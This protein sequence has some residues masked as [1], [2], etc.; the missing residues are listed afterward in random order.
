MNDD[1]DT[2]EESENEANDHGDDRLK[3]ISNLDSVD[4]LDASNVEEADIEDEEVS[5]ASNLT[6]SPS[7][8]LVPASHTF[9][10]YI[11]Q[12][13]NAPILSA[14]QEWELA[15]KLREEN[16]L[17]A[18]QS[19]IFSN[20]RHVVSIARGYSGYGL[21]MPDLVQEG[22]VGLMKAV[23]RFD[24]DQK[25]KLMT[26]ATHWVRAEINE[27]VIKNW[28]IVKIATT[29]AQRKLFFKLRSARNQ[30]GW[31]SD[32]EAGEI[33][34]KHNVTKADVYHM[35]NR[36]TNLD[37]SFDAPYQS[38][39]EHAYAPSQFL[40]D[41]RYSP[42]QIVTQ[43]NTETF[44]NEGL[45]QGLKTLDERSREIIEQ[46]WFQEDKATLRELAKKYQVSIERIRQI[47]T[48]A[49]QKL[50]GFLSQS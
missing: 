27:F 49:L 18:A 11:H 3:P 14:E 41:Y 37:T 5:N 45:Q 31:V 36:F 23:K 33:A 39:D 40:P 15:R 43:Q 22:N 28:Q 13:N 25:V 2:F 47:E 50:K 16:D 17:E 20:L 32:K 21:S 44:Q 12:V 34:E 6:P 30:I 48:K 19:L 38:D 29:K 35:E 42:E 9:E 8:A 26:F 46:R 7:N 10:S 24:P 4:E 1:Y